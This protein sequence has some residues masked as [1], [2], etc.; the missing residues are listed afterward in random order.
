MGETQKKREEQIVELQKI[1][2]EL[3]KRRAENEL[4]Q[5]KNRETEGEQAR[6]AAYETQLKDNVGDMMKDY[7]LQF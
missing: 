2:S 3:Q 1:M 6:L 4:L 5:E 7:S